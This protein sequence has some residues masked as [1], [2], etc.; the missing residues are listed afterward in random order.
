MD[1]LTVLKDDH[2]KVKS[3]FEQLETTTT[4]ATKTRVEV[5]AKIESE[6]LVHMEFEEKV[7]YPAVKAGAEKAGKELTCEAYAEHESAVGCMAKLNGLDPSDEMWKAWLMVLKEG[8]THHIKEEENEL[9]GYARD[10]IPTARRAE[11]AEEYE[12][13]KATAPKPPK[14]AP[15]PVER[16]PQIAL[17]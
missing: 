13:M 16:R 8:V 1:I 14:P 3:L 7:L 4:A 6:L 11:M 10:V 17:A 5:L 9:F 2:K 12:A 15:K